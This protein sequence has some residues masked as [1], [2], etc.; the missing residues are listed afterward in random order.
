M[1]KAELAV[2]MQI[3]AKLVAIAVGITNAGQ[4]LIQAQDRRAAAQ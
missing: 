3:V 4:Y 2:V 1:A